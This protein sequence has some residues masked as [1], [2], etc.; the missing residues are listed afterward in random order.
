MGINKLPSNIIKYYY[1][2]YYNYKLLLKK[3]SNKRKNKKQPRLKIQNEKNEKHKKK[4]TKPNINQKH[5]II[6]R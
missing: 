4:Q 2:N 1:I 3:A 5:I 6:M